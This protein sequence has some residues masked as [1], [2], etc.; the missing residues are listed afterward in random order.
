MV[1]VVHF[2]FSFSPLFSLVLVYFCFCSSF[3]ICRSHACSFSLVLVFT[4]CIANCFS[5]GIAS[6]GIKFW[7]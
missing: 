2:S 7:F 4:A 3:F 1:F 5:L 6:F